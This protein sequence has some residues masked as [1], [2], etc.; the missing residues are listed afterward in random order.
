MTAPPSR[1]ASTPQNL[2][3]VLYYKAPHMDDKTEEECTQKEKYCTSFV[4]DMEPEPSECA[5][6]EENK[7]PCND[8]ASIPR[9]KDLAKTCKNNSQAPAE[10]NSL[11]ICESR[12]VMAL[13]SCS[14]WEVGQPQ[15]LWVLGQAVQRMRTNFSRTNQWGSD[16]KG[17]E[18]S[19]TFH[20]SE[21]VD[22]E[23]SS[24][25]L[26][27]GPCQTSM[28]AHCTVIL[29]VAFAAGGV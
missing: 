22:S 19:L 1:P 14:E 20:S 8:K 25:L 10:G 6:A 16:I 23:P 3:V 12:K 21:V 27:P 7:D 28:L 4:S 29:D 26:L 2:E 17:E 18:L 13:R 15:P 11:K 9:C 5:T 24:P